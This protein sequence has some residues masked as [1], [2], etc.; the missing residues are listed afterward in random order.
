MK[1]LKSTIYSAILFM[2]MLGVAACSGGKKSEEEE[3]GHDHSEM[4]ESKDGHDHG[5]ASMDEGEG[6]TWTP[7]GNGEELIRSDF[8][9]IAGAMENIAPEVTEA[10]SDNVLKLTANGIPV[11]FVFHQSYGNIGM[12]VS[13]NASSFQGTYKLIHH[14]SNADNHEFVAVNGNNMK[15]GRIVQGDEMVF[16]ESE[17][18]SDEDWINLRVSAAG[19]HYKG[20]IGNKTVTH[21]HGDKMKNGYVGIM[22]DGIGEILIKSIE[23]VPLE[24]E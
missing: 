19:T 21:G 10:A 17:F 1:E 8:H 24:D 16:D 20:Y 3:S 4:T 18:E 6:K 14:A 13:L 11:A 7:S 9:F 2:L 5:E 12:A 15:L 23:T 22:L